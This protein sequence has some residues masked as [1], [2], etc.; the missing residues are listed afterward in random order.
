MK[1]ICIW[2][3]SIKK[4]ADEAQ[5]LAV[6]KA[7]KTR[8]PNT[9]ITIFARHGELIE[10]RYPEIKTIPTIQISKV[11]SSVASCDLFVV[12][13]GPFLE[14]RSQMISCLT[15]FS[16]AKFFRKPVITYGT[17]VLEY[18]TSWGRFFYRNLF[19]LMD[20]ITVREEVGLKLLREL[21]VKKDLLL[22]PDPRFVLEPVPIAEVQNILIQEG[23]D[24]EAPKIGITTRHL[25]EKVPDWVKRSHNYSEDNVKNANEVIGRT[26]GYLGRYAQ[27]VL[28][29]MHPSYDEDLKTAEAIKKHMEN[30]SRLKILSRLYRSL[31]LIGMIGS[32]NMVIAS[33][34]G[35]AI[36]ATVTLTPLVSIAY[37]S[38]M[39]D[40]MEGIGYGQY[41]RD[42][43]ELNY[44]DFVNI[45]EDVWQSRDTIKDQM[46]SRVEEFKDRA[47]QNAK[48]IS[49]FFEKKLS[50]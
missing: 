28:I 16:I 5:L 13:G 15:L 14:S 29:P 35:S 9:E 37:E 45:A 41:V 12:V 1:K 6:C 42:W 32:C 47:W 26:V 44:D 43:K 27:C 33:R 4:V 18:K 24:V 36:F 46:G 23:L 3:T 8:I 40:H 38:R 39:I 20:A 21:G 34:L 25:H 7:I 48:V 17:T 10:K 2:G 19:D 49:G 11:L 30:P 31:E 22:Y 50:S